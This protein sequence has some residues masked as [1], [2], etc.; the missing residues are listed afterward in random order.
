MKLRERLRSVPFVPVVLLGSLLL[1]LFVARSFLKAPAPEHVPYSSVMTAVDQGKVSRV[2]IGPDSISAQIKGDPKRELVA[3]RVPNVEEKDLLEVLR[4]HG[5]EVTGRPDK[6]SMWGPILWTVLPFLFLP[7]VLFGLSRVGANAAKAK[8]MTFGRSKAKIYDKSLE[9]PVTFADVAGVDE[10]KGELTE[11]VSFLK[12]NEKYKKIGARVPK[13]ILLVGSPGTGKTLLA[14][15][16]A[17]ESGVPFFSISGSEFVEMFVGVGASRVRDLFEQAKERAPCIIFIDE[18]DAVGKARAGA[19]GFVANE[20]REQTLNQLLIEMDGFDAGTGIVI[21]AAT[22]R[23]EI[24][25][26]ALLRAGRFDRQVLL[27]R[28]DVRGREAI[29][30]VHVKKV[31]LAPDVDLKVVAQRTP[32]MVG[33]DLANVVNEAALASV[34]AGHETVGKHDFEEAIDRIQLGLKKEGRVMTEDEKRRVAFH[35]GGHAVVAISMAHADPVHRVTIIPRSIGA[36]GATLQ[37]PTEERYLMTRAEL[38][39]RLC[40]LLAG[41]AAEELACDDVSTGSE[42]DIERATQIAHHM[43]SRFGMSEQLGP[44]TFQHSQSQFLG[45]ELERRDFSEETAR[46]IDHEVKSVITR[47]QKRAK[48]ILHQRRHALEAV[49]RELIAKETLEK[50]QLDEIVKA[51]EQRNGSGRAQDVLGHRS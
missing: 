14:R 13:G 29:L 16:V 11:I 32:G 23:P 43:V 34:R 12:E 40:V 19:A 47:E 5:V 3:D 4:S 24:L 28:P 8:P 18:L 15:A 25:D 50:E 26:K 39:D 21:M 20:E 36:L 33:A 2:E 30:R 27:D 1:A 10:A 31:Q 44:V 49:A 22:N 37:L 51:S 7:L 48:D 35:E 17:G 9:N 6:G 42:D 46:L 41:R 38:R 45:M